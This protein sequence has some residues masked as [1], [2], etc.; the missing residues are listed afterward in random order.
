MNRN[1]S[2]HMHETGNQK[3]SSYVRCAQIHSPQKLRT[4]IRI[5]KVRNIAGI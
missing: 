5:D 3:D 2:H 4:I 1:Y